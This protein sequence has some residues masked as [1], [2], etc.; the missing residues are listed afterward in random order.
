MHW[1]RRIRSNCKLT[2]GGQEGLQRRA[3]HYHSRVRAHLGDVDQPPR[4]ALEGGG[5]TAGDGTLD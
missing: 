4:H 3:D 1:E 2:R 5:D